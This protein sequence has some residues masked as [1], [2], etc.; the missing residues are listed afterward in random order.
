MFYALLLLS[1]TDAGNHCVFWPSVEW[2]N[3]LQLSLAAENQM[4]VMRAWWLYWCGLY[5]PSWLFFLQRR[6][7]LLFRDFCKYICQYMAQHFFNPNSKVCFIKSRLHS[8]FHTKQKCLCCFIC[9]NHAYKLLSCISICYFGCSPQ[10]VALTS[11]QMWTHSKLKSTAHCYWTYT[12]HSSD[13]SWI[14]AALYLE[15]QENS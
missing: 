7:F 1:C 14:M 2:V 11:P 8:H 3:T 9:K 5:W 10:P 12:E 6:V 15:L 4:N 13:R